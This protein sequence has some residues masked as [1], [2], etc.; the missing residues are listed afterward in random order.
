MHGPDPDGD[1][2]TVVGELV[3]HHVLRSWLDQLRTVGVDRSGPRRKRSSGTNPPT[4]D[5][6]QRPCAPVVLAS[7]ALES[8]C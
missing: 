7:F 2:E 3:D 1:E 8:T 6:N 5:A 4:G